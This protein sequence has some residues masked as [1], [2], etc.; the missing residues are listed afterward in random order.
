MASFEPAWAVAAVAGAAALGLA[1]RVAT[2]GRRTAALR[3][4]LREGEKEAKARR[5]HDEQR[6]KLVRRAEADLD[7][8]TRKL[9][10]AERRESQSKASAR[11]EREA[12]AEQIRGLERDLDEA[13]TRLQGL[14]GELDRSRSELGLSTRRAAEAEVRA[15]GA[16]AALAAAPPP[17]DPE[18]LRALR[19]RAESAE[20]KL[21]ERDDALARAAAEVRRLVAK[22]GTQETLYTSI[23]SELSVKKDQIREQ[24]AQ[25]ERL[26]A[27]EAKRVRAKGGGKD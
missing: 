1:L 14:E 22:A 9:A 13:R 27:L 4:A 23:R 26:Q 16:E 24:R 5:K 15:A 6:D 3:D 2:E 21:G 20:Q 25:L 18:E 19:E 11:A 12:A 8:A 10:Q 7:R 17:A